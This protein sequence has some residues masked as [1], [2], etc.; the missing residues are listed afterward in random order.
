MADHELKIET[1]VGQIVVT[2]FIYEI[3]ST[4]QDSN[5][6]LCRM[7]TADFIKATAID[8]SNSRDLRT[9]T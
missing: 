6:G 9:K 2:L 3:I 8:E 7:Q 5:S 1:S 4:V